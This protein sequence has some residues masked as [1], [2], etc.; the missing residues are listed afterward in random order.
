[1]PKYNEGKI[2]KLVLPDKRIYVGST[3]STLTKKL[4]QHKKINKPNLDNW[5]GVKIILIENVICEN[6]DQLNA[7]EYYYRDLLNPSL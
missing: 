4:Y 5:K 2:Y 3:T 1:M 6:A 7:R